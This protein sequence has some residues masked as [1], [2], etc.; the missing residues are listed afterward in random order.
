MHSQCLVRIIEF[1]SLAFVIKRLSLFEGGGFQFGN[2]KLLQAIL[3][4]LQCESPLVG[5]KSA[6]Q[7]YVQRLLF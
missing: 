7:I 2:G 5:I 4:G 3:T 6:K 1:C